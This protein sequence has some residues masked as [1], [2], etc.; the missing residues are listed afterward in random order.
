MYWALGG[1]VGLDKVIPTKDAKALLSPGKFLTASVGLLILCFA[2]LAY[3]LNFQSSNTM[4]YFTEVMYAGWFLSLIFLLRFIGD[5]NMLGLFKKIKSTTFA[6]YDTK[7]FM[8]LTLFWSITF[9]LTT[10]YAR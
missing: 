2:F 5:F 1:T 3:L 7:Y 8:P 6:N 4:P 10:Y 9:A